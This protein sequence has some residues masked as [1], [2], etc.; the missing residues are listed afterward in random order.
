MKLPRSG[1]WFVFASL[2]LPNIASGIQPY[3]NRGSFNYNGDRA[4]D[5]WMMWESPGGFFSDDP[6][7]E[8]GFEISQNYYDSCTSFTNLPFAYDDCETAGVDEDSDGM[9]VFGWGS[10][11]LVVDQCCNAFSRHLGYHPPLNDDPI[12]AGTWYYA[13][14]DLFCEDFCPSYNSSYN[15][16]WQEVDR[17]LCSS[18]DP[19]CMYGQQGS[20]FVEGHLYYGTPLEVHYL[21]D[22]DT[23]Q[24]IY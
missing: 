12:A 22:P 19:W 10:Y 20:S 11:H 21:Y 7:Y 16:G 9:F 5:V 23:G 1:L 24:R 2:L 4:F 18:D 13:A 14:L 15:L 6:G 17:I 3:A 8:Q